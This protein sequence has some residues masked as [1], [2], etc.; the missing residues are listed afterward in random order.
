M[1]IEQTNSGVD[2][3][4]AGISLHVGWEGNEVRL[5]YHANDGRG[6]GNPSTMATA[7]LTNG[8]WYH[9]ASIRDANSVSIYVNGELSAAYDDDPTGAIDFDGGSWD[10]TYTWIGRDFP[11]GL[12][13]TS[14]QGVF[15]GKMSSVGVC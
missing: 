12:G 4:N 5:V 7:P 8:V 15:A 10:H 6:G 11:N 2:S 3:L 13:G 14:V 9:I 1:S